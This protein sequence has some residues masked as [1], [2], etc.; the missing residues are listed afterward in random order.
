MP[1]DTHAADGIRVLLAERTGVTERRMMGGLVFMV[2]G[3]MCVTASGRGGI[4]VRV[5]PEAQKRVLEEPHVKAV[6]MAGRTMGGFVRVMPEG[7][8]TAA[9]L[10]KWVKRGLD[11][12]STLPAKTRASGGS[13]RKRPP[14]RA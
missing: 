10:R 7:Y 2:N 14:T 8:R 9:S 5:G 11:Y 4:L 13:K 12:V 3:H 1:Y 6:T